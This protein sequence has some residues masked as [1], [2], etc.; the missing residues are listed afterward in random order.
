VT[1]APGRVSGRAPLAAEGGR[2]G[3]GGGQGTG[4]GTGEGTGQGI[5]RSWWPPALS[6]LLHGGTLAGLLLLTRT[7]PPA[8][9]VTEA[10]EIIWQ[11]TEDESTG[12]GSAPPPP[13]IAR[14]APP[15]PGPPQPPDPAAPPP[16]A[17]VAA[18]PPPVAN[19]SAVPPPPAAVPPPITAPP[20]PPSVAV[21]D[22]LPPPPDAASPAVAAVPPPEPPPAEPPPELAEALPE[23]P[24][25]APPA[26]R[27][28]QR[29][30]VAARQPPASSQTEASR[31]AV[32][33]FGRVEGGVSRPAEPIAQ[34]PIRYPR[35]SERQGDQGTVVL[36]VQVDAQG[37]ASNVEIVATSG[38]RALDSAAL[39]AAQNWRFRPALRDGQPVGSTVRAP[40]TFRIRDQRPW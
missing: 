18:A 29:T 38:F 35:D 5:G 22:A 17:V 11:Q 14:P 13:E 27:L 28:P 2:S 25:P 1:A 39:E 24:P 16:P 33:G 6:L 15:E 34:P 37:H 40:V 9:A 30:A 21:A 19:P 36:I 7:D 4:Q 12:T 23:P 20:L 8:P 26:P 31:P 32:L 3:P 10:V